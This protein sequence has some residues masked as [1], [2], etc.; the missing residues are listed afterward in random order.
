MEC[1]QLEARIE[2]RLMNTVIDWVD[3]VC[4][5]V[6]YDMCGT[7][8]AQFFL[9][10]MICR[11]SIYPITNPDP[12]YSHTHTRGCMNN[13]ISSDEVLY[14]GWLISCYS[15]IRTNVTVKISD[16]EIS[17]MSLGC[18]IESRIQN[19]LDRVQWLT[20]GGG[21]TITITTSCSK[22]SERAS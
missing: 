13:W 8:R 4:C 5:V 6:V 12:V 17:L 11:S 1:P 7:V 21:P 2:Q 22:K 18:E 9:V 19:V 14:T 15:K 10:V 16:T 3:L 20:S